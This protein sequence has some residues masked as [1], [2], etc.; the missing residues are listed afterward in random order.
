MDYQLKKTYYL[1]IK[2]DPKSQEQV[3]GYCDM[4]KGWKKIID[5]LLEDLDQPDMEWDCRITQV[6]EK[7]GGLRFYI[8]AA[9][10]AVWKR[11]SQA[12]QESYKTCMV[13]GE[14]GELRESGWWTTQCDACY[15]KEP[16]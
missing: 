12:C 15:D 8:G 16:K 5:S 7:F 3:E 9:S 6:K 13:C 11:I 4:G 14:P 10:E 2:E 1:G